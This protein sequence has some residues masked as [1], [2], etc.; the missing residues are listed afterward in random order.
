MMTL[1]RTVVE[2]PHAVQR[3]LL[4]H[5]FS[6]A[7]LGDA[8]GRELDVR[9]FASFVLGAPPASALGNAVAEGWPQTDHLLAN[10]GEQHAQLI[11][12]DRRYPRPGLPEPG[13]EAAPE[14]V[15]Y[16]GGTFDRFDTPADFEAKLQS[17]RQHGNGGEG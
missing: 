14:P 8:D 9:L 11:G 2:Y 7:G 10:L 5:G 16:A 13:P 1:A 12:L 15:V 3:D 17:F 4:C 6:W